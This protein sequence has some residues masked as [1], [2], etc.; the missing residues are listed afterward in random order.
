[1]KF[2]NLFTVSVLSFL[3]E[4]ESRWSSEINHHLQELYNALISKSRSDI[5][6]SFCMIVLW[7]ALDIPVQLSRSLRNM[8]IVS[9]LTLNVCTRIAMV[10]L[11][12]CY[13]ARR[14]ILHWKSSTFW[15]FH[16]GIFKISTSCVAFNGSVVVTFVDLLCWE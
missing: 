3:Q 10:I 7:C 14:Y 1:M 13:H 2:I 15:L 4:S 16:E 8:Y 6:V 5:R 9:S 11:W 12:I